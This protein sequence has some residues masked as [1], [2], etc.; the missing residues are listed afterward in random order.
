MRFA[1]ADPPYIGQAKR[2]YGGHKDYAGEVDHRKLIDRLC[3]EFP[4]GWALSLSIKSLQAILPMCPEDVLTLAW[5]KPIAP[6]MGDNRH[7]SWEPVILRGGRKPQRAVKSHL[8][9]SPP[10]FTFRERPPEHVIGEKPEGFC[11]WVFEAAGLLPEDDL[12]DLF[13]GSGAVGRAWKTYAEGPLAT[14]TRR[15]C[16]TCEASP[17]ER[18]TS[19]KTGRPCALHAARVAS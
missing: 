9:L 4:D 14:A 18:C 13:P 15:P 10:Q 2:H 17:Y 16:P 3:D 19:L 5:V 6:P 1:Y 11:H 7:Y 8:T 12:H